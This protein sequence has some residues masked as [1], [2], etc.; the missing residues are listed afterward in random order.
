MV[1]R[2]LDAAE[3]LAAED[4]IDAE[5]VNV[6]IIKPIHSESV[7]ASLGKTGVAVTAEEARITGGLGDTIRHVAAE[8]H[9]VPVF[10]LG[11]RDE[12]GVSG[13]AEACMEYFGLTSRAIADRARDALALKPIVAHRPIMGGE[14]PRGAQNL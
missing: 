14:Q 12:F 5:V 1:W 3:T 13:T 8:Q 4:G 2:A 6:A 10:A 11:M 9:P 7:L